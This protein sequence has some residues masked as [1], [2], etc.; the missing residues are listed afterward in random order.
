MRLG[1]SVN[2]QKL[3][4]CCCLLL[5]KA[6]FCLM[7]DVKILVSISFTCT[8][9]FKENCDCAIC[10]CFPG[11]CKAEI[12]QNCTVTSLWFIWGEMQLQPS[13]AVGSD[14]MKHKNIA[15]WKWIHIQAQFPRAAPASPQCKG[16]GD[17]LSQEES[18]QC[19]FEGRV[20]RRNISKTPTPASSCS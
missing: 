18:S 17:V 4:F 13:R 11:L 12:V 3:V 1:W 16:W 10:Y 15:I 5:Q 2:K 7:D 9:L 19:L 8:W 6:F 14:I 20:E